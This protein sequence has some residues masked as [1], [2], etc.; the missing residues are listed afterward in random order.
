MIQITWPLN[1]QPRQPAYQHMENL[2]ESS[3]IHNIQ[4]YTCRA[5]DR[6]F[7]TS[8]GL[9]NH[10]ENACTLFQLSRREKRE[11]MDKW[12]DSPP[13]ITQLYLAVKILTD[14]VVS[15]EGELRQIKKNVGRKVPDRDWLNV[16]SATPA[17]G[18][19][20]DWTA[21]LSPNSHHLQ[22]V[23]DSNLSEGI[24]HL[25]NEFGRGNVLLPIIIS[26]K[27]MY[28]YEQKQGH[29]F[30]EWHP[31]I[32]EE[33]RD[34]VDSICTQF[35]RLFSQWKERNAYHLQTDGNVKEL[36]FLYMQKI[37]RTESMSER[38]YTAVKKWFSTR[39]YKE[40]S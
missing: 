5:C 26:K 15:L 37:M 23:F 25:L 21:T 13:T 40:L 39:E 8:V 12:N 38:I 11:N 28:I 14:K 17:S 29:S 30:P 1:K 9:K 20:I 18:S 2:P 22:T 31:F 33:F 35:I 27:K 3:S 6:K 7:V 19:F 34:F 10:N 4:R 24:I 16:T 36:Y 32:E